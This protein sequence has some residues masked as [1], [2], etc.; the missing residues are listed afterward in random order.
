[1]FQAIN[2]N[3]RETTPRAPNSYIRASVTS[4]LSQRYRSIRVRERHLHC[5]RTRN[6]RAERRFTIHER[7][8]FI[9][10]RMQSASTRTDGGTGERMTIQAFQ[11]AVWSGGRNADRRHAVIDPRTAAP[12]CRQWKHSHQHP[13]TQHTMNMLGQLLTGARLAVSLCVS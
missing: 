6:K 5:I 12:P 7:R 8:S 1:M 11:S 9:F 3:C 2:A 13:P 4:R 10:H